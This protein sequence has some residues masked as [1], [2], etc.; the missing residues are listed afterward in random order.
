MVRMTR[1]ELE[2]VSVEFDLYQLPALSLKRALMRTAVGGGLAT[3][4]NSGRT[5]IRAL[6]EIDLDVRDGERLAIIGHNGAGK[7]TLLRVMAGIYAPTQGTVRHQGRCVPIFDLHSGFDDEATGYEN[8]ILRGLLMGFSRAEMEARTEEIAAF[9]G[10]GEF[11][12]FPV[13]TYSS[14][15]LLRL[16]FSISTSA[17]ADILLMDEWIAT[18]DQSFLSKANQRLHDLVQRSRILVFASHSPD[19][20]RKVC[21]RALLLDKGTIRMAGSVDDVL[22]AYASERTI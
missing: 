15:M 8:I 20:L 5:V 12:N 2:N 16:L 17:P 1:L 6:R 3:A 4:E 13:R 9:S 21:N 18:G 19:L 14:G 22:E 10:L 7:T 11:L